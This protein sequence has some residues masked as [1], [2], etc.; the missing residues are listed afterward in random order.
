MSKIRDIP[1]VAGSIIWAKQIERQLNMYM[2]R[3]EA[4]LGKGWETHVDGQKLKADGDSFRMKLNTQELFEEWSR[5]VAQKNIQNTG[6]IFT[7]DTQRASK[8]TIYSLK[9]NFSTD[10]IMLTKEARNMKWLMSR[11]PLSIVNKAHTARQMYPYAISLM[12]NVTTYKRI[13][14]RV[15]EK[16]TCQLL[17]AGMKKDI[18]NLII[19]MSSLVWDS[20]KLESSVQKFSDAIYNFR[21]KID[22]LISVETTIE[23]QLKELDTCP[24]DETKFSEILYEIQKSIDYLNLK[25]F[26]NLPQWVLKLDEEIE[27]KFAQRL[28][29]AIKIWVD[30][31]LDRK[32]SGSPVDSENGTGGGGGGVISRRRNNQYNINANFN[33]VDNFNKFLNFED[34]MSDI[35]MLSNVD[36]SSQAS[37][38]ES[39]AAILEKMGGKP[40]IKPIVL[41]IL[42]RNQLLYVIPSIEDAREHLISQ[43]EEFSSVVTTQKRIQHSRYQV[44]ME[45]ESEYKVTYKNL[46]NKFQNGVKLLEYSFTAIDYMLQQA[47]DYI[48]I[49]LHFQSLWDL[50][51]DTLYAKLG[52]NL[53][54]WIGCLNEMKESRKSFDTQETQR[55]FGP[56]KIDYNKVQ[57][58]VNVKYDAWHKEVAKQHANYLSI[59]TCKNQ[60]ILCCNIYKGIDQVWCTVGQ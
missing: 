44:T 38:T 34:N 2:G 48:K 5:K 60:V 14:D 52:N 6:R 57:S 53:S 29:I 17:V 46:L 50:Q 56:I 54:A 26:S 36:S 27:K 43:L 25:G 45:A 10:I 22:E 58:K 23:L 47:Q 12:E 33:L 3:V 21:E 8:G 11:V 20:Y 49:W 9:V 42:I 31:L 13:C 30:V 1:P 51:P 28:L 59:R 55:S 15:N 7:V 16:R 41:E 24:Y 19:D 40:R 37:P 4:V 39:E 32:R 35:T 18:Q